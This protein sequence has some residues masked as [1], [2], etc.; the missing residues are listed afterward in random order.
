[1]APNTA[2]YPT[3]FVHNQNLVDQTT[4][5]QPGGKFPDLG[6]VA[7]MSELPNTFPRQPS[8][9]R[10]P[11]IS[12]MLANARQASGAAQILTNIA[13]EALSYDPNNQASKFVP[14]SRSEPWKK[15]TAPLPS[16]DEL[17]SGASSS[18]VEID[19]GPAEADPFRIKRSWTRR[20]TGCLTCRRRK[21]RCDETRDCCKSVLRL[22]SSS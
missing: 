1:M 21:K 18:L 11:T 14:I 13:K 10:G 5:A 17:L 16:V 15:G 22:S 4:L 7:Y 19:T 8:I 6:S 12:E 2:P 3:T 20:K 9:H